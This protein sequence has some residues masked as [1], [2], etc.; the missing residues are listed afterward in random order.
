[1]KVVGEMGD[2]REALAQIEALE[3][4]V[5]TLDCRLPG[6]EGTEVAAGFVVKE[7]AP[8]I[9][10]EAARARR[11]RWCAP[12]PGTTAAASPCAAAR[13]RAPPSRC[14]CRWHRLRWDACLACVTRLLHRVTGWLQVCHTV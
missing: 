10:V 4:G 8:E 2:R 13:E 6:L 12:W 11:W 1:M 5:A 3:P 9:I 7:E 14:A